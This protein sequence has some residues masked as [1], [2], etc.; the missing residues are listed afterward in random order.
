VEPVANPDTGFLLTNLGER[1]CD[2]WAAARAIQEAVRRADADLGVGTA[3]PASLIMAAPF[4]AARI[5]ASFASA[6]GLLTLLMAMVGLYGIQSHIVARRTREVGVRMAIGASASQ[7]RRMI[8]GEGYRPVLQGL[9]LGLLFGVFVRLLLRA[10]VN[11]NIDPFD[12]VAFVLVPL[13]L[14]TAAFVACYLPA[15]R[16]A[17]VDPNEALRHL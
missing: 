2:P 9:V 5:A 8:L 16:A 10:T 13:P 14:I 12:P 1:N 15:R 3:G 6:L 7:I 17:R 11:G 4:F